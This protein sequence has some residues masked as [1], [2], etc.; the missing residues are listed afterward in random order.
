MTTNDEVR[1]Y[2][3]AFSE[4]KKDFYLDLAL[5]RQRGPGTSLRDMELYF[6]YIVD[7]NDCAKIEKNV[8]AWFEGGRVNGAQMRLGAS[9]VLSREMHRE[10]PMGTD[11]V[12]GGPQAAPLTLQYRPQLSTPPQ[13]EP[14]PGTP[15]Q[16]PP[17][18]DDDSDDDGNAGAT[19]GNTGNDDDDDDDDGDSLI[20]RGRRGNGD[21]EP[22]VLVPATPE[23][24]SPRTY[25]DAMQKDVDAFKNNVDDI[26]EGEDGNEPDIDMDWEGTMEKAVTSK[27]ELERLFKR[28]SAQDF[29]SEADANEVRKRAREFA[30][31]ASEMD[32]H[33]KLAG[34]RTTSSSAYHPES[35]DRALRASEIL[36]AKKAA[37]GEGHQ[38]S[39]GDREPPPPSNAIAVNQKEPENIEPEG[40]PKR[41]PGP[42]E[43]EAVRKTPVGVHDDYVDKHHSEFNKPVG[44][45]PVKMK[46]PININGDLEDRPVNPYGINPKYLPGK[47]L[48]E[49][50]FLYHHKAENYNG[51]SYASPE[52][53]AVGKYWPGS[54]NTATRMYKD[55]ELGDYKHAEELLNILEGREVPKKFRGDA[56]QE[57]ARIRLD[58]DS[59]LQRAPTPVPPSPESENE[60]KRRLRGEKAHQV[61]L[62][63]RPSRPLPGQPQA[64]EA[65]REVAAV[66]AHAF[67]SEA[68][69]LEIEKSKEDPNRELL[70]HHGNAV[71]RIH[72]LEKQ[73]RETEATHLQ[74]KQR[75]E[76]DLSKRYLDKYRKALASQRLAERNAP[77]DSVIKAHIAEGVNKVRGEIE[78]RIRAEYEE[79]RKTEP[80]IFPPEVH[81]K[82]V[83][84]DQQQK[85]LADTEIAL[86]E[87][88][89]LNEQQKQALETM[90]VTASQ[91][92]EQELVKR[93]G[94]LREE[95]EVAKRQIAA[96]EQA[97]ASGATV[98]MELRGEL[99]VLKAESQSQAQLI[100]QL[101]HELLQANADRQTKQVLGERLTAALNQA[102]SVERDRDLAREQLQLHQSQ[103]SE[104]RAQADD[105]ETLRRTLTENAAKLASV[106]E[107]LKTQEDNFKGIIDTQVANI[108]K[109]SQDKKLLTDEV[110]TVRE[111]RTK[112][113]RDLESLQQRVFIVK[114]TQDKKIHDFRGKLLQEKR[115][116]NRIA[117]ELEQTNTQMSAIETQRRQVQ[118]QLNQSKLHRAEAE[119]QRQDAEARAVAI[120]HE[121]TRKQSEAEEK[122]RDEAAREATVLDRLKDSAPHLL[123]LASAAGASAWKH[124][125][126]VGTMAAEALPEP[127][128]V[129]WDEF[130]SAWEEKAKQREL[131]EAPKKQPL[132]RPAKV[133]IPTEPTLAVDDERQWLESENIDDERHTNKGRN[134][135]LDSHKKATESK[136]K[137]STFDPGDIDDAI[138]SIDQS[139]GLKLGKGKES[140]DE[141]EEE[142][143]ESEDEEVA[144]AE[145][146]IANEIFTKLKRANITKTP[147]LVDTYKEGLDRAVLLMLVAE[148]DIKYLESKG[149]EREARNKRSVLKK[150]RTTYPGVEEEAHRWLQQASV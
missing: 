51:I 47:D 71:K 106:E 122:V 82:F 38:R 101:K 15:P 102:S 46:V 132:K 26:P 34:Y 76:K 105:R 139:K 144:H 30:K 19:G 7:G 80:P 64:P 45:H 60:M 149:K 28:L 131:E 39:P 96:R 145:K 36:A 130:E 140:D 22:D 115:Q 8:Y 141:G 92:M 49:N 147:Q 137:K 50:G 150:L 29:V 117:V 48:G 120:S 94:P 95:F 18:G 143:A 44:K 23:P 89:A 12:E 21:D 77:D 128:V 10:L 84:F 112:L 52:G 87:A 73:M 24:R 124:L 133:K 61:R 125:M 41:K 75:L 121:A 116:K 55:I 78:Q 9:N 129:P 109:L 40:A 119:R 93:L 3:E 136:R 74:E 123:R 6:K 35:V 83:A 13:P 57:L 69:A 148:Q 142:G 86:R 99:D 5:L 108:A 43:P 114:S 56:R 135:A 66:N 111:K 32:S 17:R 14:I 90:R 85:R 42:P 68:Q 134:A 126:R 1:T 138:R 70:I 53:Q 79:R 103:M 31:L 91:Q 110:A 97:V 27:V 58:L 113:K 16:T 4:V 37:K 107:R 146:E 98:D 81:Q 59:R 2:L 67:G 25:N 100:N 33:E 63:G 88:G 72:L 54:A 118:D 127:A 62:H 104:L 65:R 20:R 11:P